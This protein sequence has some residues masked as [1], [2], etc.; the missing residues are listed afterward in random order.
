MKKLFQTIFSHK[1]IDVIDATTGEK[2]KATY[3]M[4][5]GLS[6]NINYKTA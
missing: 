1:T 5:L 2:Q 3:V 4:L 6:I